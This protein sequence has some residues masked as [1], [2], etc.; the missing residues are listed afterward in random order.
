MMLTRPRHPSLHLEEVVPQLRLR[1][2]SQ[3]LLQAELVV[4]RH[5]VELH[6]FEIGVG[7]FNFLSNVS[8][9]SVLKRKIVGKGEFNENGEI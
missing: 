3:V 6:R 2:G 4:V 8:I 9:Y 7:S 5:G 1:L